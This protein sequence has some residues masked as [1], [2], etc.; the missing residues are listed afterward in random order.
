MEILKD[1]NVT[2]YTTTLG[3]TRAEA[4]EHLRILDTS[5]D[6]LI[7]DYI[8]AAHQF[9]YQETSILID[10]TATGYLE[11]FRDFIIPL[12]G[13]SSIAIYYYDT[14]NTRTL[15]NSSNYI[16]T[17]GKIPKVEFIGVEP[18]TYDRTFP[19]EVE[20]TTS[21]NSNPL[22]KQALKMIVADLFETRQTNVQNASVNREMSRATAWQ[23]SLISCRV[24]I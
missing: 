12:G 14:D 9:L 20:V 15:L 6:N 4:K 18:T 23:L 11:Y 3:L 7:D 17:N 21:T 22:V 8:S 10:G 2:G 13:V 5:H 1:I 24:E 16:F 19:Y